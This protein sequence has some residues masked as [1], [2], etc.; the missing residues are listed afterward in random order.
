M[1][2]GQSGWVGVGGMWGVLFILE[3]PYYSLR[4][5]A[6]PYLRY[7]NSIAPL[8]RVACLGCFAGPTGI[9][10]GPASMLLWLALEREFCSY[11]EKFLQ[12][13]VSF[14]VGSLFIEIVCVA[15][16]GMLCC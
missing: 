15:A 9:H 13:G 3:V 11:L 16:W 8:V 1:C 14:A 4:C 5:P 12:L 10:L 6:Y 7:A 2:V